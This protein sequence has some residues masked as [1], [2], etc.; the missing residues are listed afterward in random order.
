MASG[1]KGSKDTGGKELIYNGNKIKWPCLTECLNA[2]Q[3]VWNG[4]KRKPVESSKEMTGAKIENK[5][6]RVKVSVKF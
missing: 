6:K 3:L 2:Y 4:L 1:G 5:E